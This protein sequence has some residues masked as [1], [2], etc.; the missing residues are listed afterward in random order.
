MALKARLDYGTGAP[1]VSFY[2]QAVVYPNRLHFYALAIEVDCKSRSTSTNPES[3]YPTIERAVAEI[4]EHM[5][6]GISKRQSPPMRS[7]GA[8]F[9]CT[10]WVRSC[11]ATSPF[12]L[13][14]LLPLQGA[15][16]PAI[17]PIIG[18]LK[19]TC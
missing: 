3:S 16:L 8:V 17:M 11:L 15:A 9:Y 7:T 12:P 19:P 18:S 10:E 2:G 1:A 5:Y 14:H 4:C 13:K 6:C